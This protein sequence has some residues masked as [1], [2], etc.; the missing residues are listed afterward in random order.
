MRN[1]TLP[2]RL[3]IVYRVTIQQ[4]GACWESMVLGTKFWRVSSDCVRWSH[5]MEEATV[6]KEWDTFGAC[7]QNTKPVLTLPAKSRGS[8]RAAFGGGGGNPP[9]AAEPPLGGHTSL[10]NPIRKGKGNAQ[11]GKGSLITASD[12]LDFMA[13]AVCFAVRRVR[14]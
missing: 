4:K 2:A 13:F 6:R 8:C 3:V 7:C 11:D 14:D 10:A 9:L 5:D 1:R 12:P